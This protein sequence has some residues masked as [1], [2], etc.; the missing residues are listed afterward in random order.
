LQITRPIP[1]EV[2]NYGGRPYL[3]FD[4]PDLV[5][6]IIDGFTDEEVKAIR[7]GLGS[8]NQWVDSTNQLSNNSLCE[9]LKGIYR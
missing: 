7:H 6:D 9:M 3:V 5:R 4:A 1:E 2:S 8:V